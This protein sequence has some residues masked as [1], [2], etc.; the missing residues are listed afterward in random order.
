MGAF[1]RVAA[2]LAIPSRAARRNIF[3]VLL[4]LAAAA[5]AARAGDGVAVEVIDRQA[6]YGV[7]ATD[8]AGLA[9]EMAERGPQHPTG[10]RAWAYTAWAM[11]AR[12]AVERTAAGCRLVEPTIVLDVSTTLPHW[13]PSAPARASL[14]SAWKRMLDQASAH[15]AAHRGH[16]IDAANAAA[17]DIGRIGPGPDCADVERRVR[18]ALRR[19]SA[20]ATRRGRA[21]DRDTD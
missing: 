14:K 1:G 17:A 9:R 16:G 6:P 13:R 8:A 19:A 12:Y 4:A 20:E 11:R 15:E 5:P 21:F 7:R 18:A 3:R 10:R 2:A